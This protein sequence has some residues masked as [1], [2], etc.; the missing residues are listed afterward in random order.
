MSVS[1]SFVRSPV[2]TSGDLE[3]G[4][5]VF[6][7]AANSAATS[8]PVG[9]MQG[10]SFGNYSDNYAKATI[11]LTD[12]QANDST[13]NI[14]LLPGGSEQ[15]NFE[16]RFIKDVTI[17]AVDEPLTAGATTASALVAATSSLE[18]L[19]DINFIEA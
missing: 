2:N 5:I 4:I 17:I 3:N 1:S 8:T 12:S 6:D 18:G 9:K 11:T 19:V 10:V 7:Q 16:G 13:H 14:M 15:Y